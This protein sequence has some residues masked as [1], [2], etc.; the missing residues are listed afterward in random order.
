VWERE[1]TQLLD[2]Y[3]RSMPG[4]SALFVAGTGSWSI[5]VAEYALAA[6]FE[7]LGLVELLDRE[8]VGSVVHGLPVRAVDHLPPVGERRVVLGVGLHRPDA[9]ARL[10]REGWDPA[11]AILHPR[12]HVSESATTAE[13]TLVGP[14]AVVGAGSVVGRHV[15]LARGALVGHHVRIGNFAVVNPGAIIGGNSTI[16]RGVAIGMAAAVLN[17]IHVRARAVVAAGAVVRTDVPNGQRV[18][19]VPARPYSA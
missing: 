10:V 5:E 6:G 1:R 2:H 8:R 17:G 19:G 13:G 16:G 15:V 3:D 18:Q 11:P 7:V 4:L 14:M 12:A 9:W